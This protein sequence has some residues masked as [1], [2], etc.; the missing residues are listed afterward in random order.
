MPKGRFLTEADID[1]LEERLRDVFATKED[2][3]NYRS[4]L[5]SRLDKILGEILK[6]REEQTVLS[7]R[8]SG[9]EERI[10]TL[11]KVSPI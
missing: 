11:E 1:Y 6:S 5:L 7:H 2:F 4:E 10:S 9:H 8:V 3:A